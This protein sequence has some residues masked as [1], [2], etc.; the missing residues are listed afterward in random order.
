MLYISTL[1]SLISNLLKRTI[2]KENDFRSLFLWYFILCALC[3]DL[4]QIISAMQKLFPDTKLPED[5]LQQI[6]IRDL[7]SNLT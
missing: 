6:I 4:C 5:I 2:K 3:F 7:P 1:Y